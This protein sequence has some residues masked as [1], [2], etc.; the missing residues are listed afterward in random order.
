M[1]VIFGIFGKK[2]ILKHLMHRTNSKKVCSRSV[3]NRPI[4]FWG[5]LHRKLLLTPLTSFYG[6]N[7]FGCIYILLTLKNKKQKISLHQLLHFGDMFSNGIF[8]DFCKKPRTVHFDL[9]LFFHFPVKLVL[10]TNGLFSWSASHIK[11]PFL[12]SR[13]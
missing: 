5:L 13:K 12:I 7:A 10:P 4:R 6:Y 11:L 2:L 8:L 1:N 9:I 3:L